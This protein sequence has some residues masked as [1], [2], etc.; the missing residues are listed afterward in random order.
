MT[1]IHTISRVRSDGNILVPVGMDE[2][3]TEVEVTIA[4]A[5]SARRAADMTQSEY[6]AFL[7]SFSDK[8]VG[9]FPELNDPPPELIEPL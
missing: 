9:D 2:A 4:P 1:T 3:G 8:W 6:Q 5:P 7:E